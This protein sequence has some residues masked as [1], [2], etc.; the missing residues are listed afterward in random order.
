MECL[1]GLFL[2][3]PEAVKHWKEAEGTGEG[4]TSALEEL[5]RDALG[6]ILK[7]DPLTLPILL[8]QHLLPRN[9]GFFSFFLNKKNMPPSLFF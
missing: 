6:M 2:Q 5:N 9:M 7:Y 4:V 1:N 8:L 3:I